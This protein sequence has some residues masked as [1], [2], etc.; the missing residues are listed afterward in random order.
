[1][2]EELGL[3]KKDSSREKSV[4]VFFRKGVFGNLKSWDSYLVA[5][6]TASGYLSIFLT[7]NRSLIGSL[8]SVMNLRI[9]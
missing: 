9:S 1:M 7:S 6:V 4:R 2:I 3:G 8:K 5:M